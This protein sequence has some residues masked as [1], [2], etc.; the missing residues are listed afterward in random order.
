MYKSRR[1]SSESAVNPVR[2]ASKVANSSPV[3]PRSILHKASLALVRHRI[4]TT[5]STH[6]SLDQRISTTQEQLQS[7]TSTADYNKIQQ[8]TPSPTD[9]AF[10]EIHQS[11]SIHP[12]KKQKHTSTKPNLSRQDPSVITPLRHDKS[13]HNLQAD[14]G[15]ATVAMDKSEYDHK[16]ADI[17]NS[18]CYRALQKDPTIHQEEA[19]TQASKFLDKILHPLM[20]NTENHIKNSNQFASFIQSLTLQPDDIMISFD[21]VSLFTN[22]PTS[23]IVNEGFKFMEEFEQNAIATAD[24]RLEIWLRYV[25]DTFVI[26]QHGQDSLQRFLEHINGLHS[27]IQFTMEQEK[28]SSI[29]FIGV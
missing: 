13:I 23:D 9:H 14:K 7:C 11:L 3:V 15:N 20:G 25:D 12:S 19:A 10:K 26:W 22:V 18:G 5:R 27:S 4:S 24:Y 1:F 21:V 17:L 28:D 8:L 2:Q 6:S 16:V 29:S